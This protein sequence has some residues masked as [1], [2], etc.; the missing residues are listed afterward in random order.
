MKILQMSSTPMAGVPYLLKDI[1]NKYSEH[2]CKTCTGPSGYRDGRMWAK[3][4]A[5]L[6]NGILTRKLIAW[7][8]VVLLHNG[9][10]YRI[11]T[12]D[13]ALRSKKLLCYHH[14]EPTPPC[15]SKRVSR[16]WAKAGVP[17]Y[18]IA[19]GHA[20]MY[21]NVPVLPNLIDINWE[22][23]RPLR[24]GLARPFVKIGYAPSNR[25]T[26][27]NQHNSFM[28]QY[29]YSSKG[30]FYTKPI[31][32]RLSKMPGVVVETYWG[33]PFEECMKRRRDC[34]IFID[35]VV[36]GSYHRSTLEA[37]AHG[38][39]AINGISRETWAVVRRVTGSEVAPWVRCGPKD[40]ETVLL[41]LIND[42]QRI[43]DVG[44]RARQWMENYWHP[45]KL[46]EK[47]YVPAFEKAKK[48]CG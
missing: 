40:L 37:M 25:Q 5:N 2:E 38:Q 27:L 35:E 47:F 44:V 21:P 32:D 7:A 26:S 31:L 15:P 4:D 41:D 20:L 14:S 39:V 45:R 42:R 9:G 1:I 23:M 13:R 8:D 48:P 16:R 30:W 18:V 33:I 3:P 6:A 22:L 43:H 17:E 29:R 10:M 24:K 19:Q 28:K 46:L 12:Y 36:T 11:K 34:D